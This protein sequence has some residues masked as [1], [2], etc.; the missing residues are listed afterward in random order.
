MQN[1][2]IF[3]LSTYTGHTLSQTLSI[4]DCSL[5]QHTVLFSLV[6]HNSELDLCLDFPLLMEMW[7][8]HLLALTEGS[9]FGFWA[10]VCTGICGSYFMGTRS[11]LYNSDLMIKYLQ[12]FNNEVQD[13]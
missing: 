9:L 8:G 1:T 4:Q 10:N 7:G 13:A 3:F 2:V 11:P 12:R 5:L 6:L